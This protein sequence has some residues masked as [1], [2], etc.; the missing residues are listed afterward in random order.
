MFANPLVLADHVPA[1]HSYTISKNMPNGSVRTN[2]AVAASFMENLSFRHDI[3]E[4]RPKRKNRN[5]AHFSY[6]EYDAVTG[7][8]Y[9]TTVD[10]TVG[11]HKKAS[12]TVATRLLATAGSLIGVGSFATT[13]I[14]G[15][16]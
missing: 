9:E 15:G 11:R 12:E 2:L 3:Q 14:R 16:Y 4:N 13:F 8:A 1:N 5:N 7:E 6:T 10:V